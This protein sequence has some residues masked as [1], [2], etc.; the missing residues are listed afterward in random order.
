MSD[1]QWTEGWSQAIGLLL[2]G[3]DLGSDQRGE[4][5]TDSTFYL[6]LNASAGP[7]AFTIPDG[8]RGS[9]WKLVLDTADGHPPRQDPLPPVVT[10]LPETN[11]VPDEDLRRPGSQVVLVGRS[12]VLIERT[13]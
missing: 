11:S 5:I 3:D 9:S 6:M 2:V 13:V 7:V 1:K 8:S 12:L 4:Q 10:G